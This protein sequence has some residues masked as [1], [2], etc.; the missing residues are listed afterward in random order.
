MDLYFGV[1]ENA[2]VEIWW[3]FFRCFLYQYIFYF[4]YINLKLLGIKS[5]LN[6]IRKMLIHIKYS[7][8][9]FFYNK[10]II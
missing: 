1:S 8:A 4:L 3:L 10:I 6:V 2:F 5:L 7:I 9:Q